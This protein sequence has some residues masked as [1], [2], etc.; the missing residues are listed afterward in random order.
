MKKENGSVVLEY[1]SV[2]FD[3]Q[4]M[5]LVEIDGVKCH[6]FKGYL[7]TFWN[8]DFGDDICAKGCFK[9]SL[10]VRQPKLMVQHGRGE[11]NLPVGIF[12]VAVEDD[13]GLYVEGAMPEEDTFVSGRLVP[14]MKIKSITTMSI[15]FDTIDCEYMKQEERTIQSIKKS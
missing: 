13:K 6:K 14:Q 4:E 11:T 8:I 3:M 2:P 7:S 1:K 10:R 15:G 9:E 5:K 12:P